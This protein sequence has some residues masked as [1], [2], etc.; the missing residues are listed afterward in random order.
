MQTVVYI[1]GAPV[2]KG[3][4][5]VAVQGGHAHAYTPQRTKDYEWLVQQCFAAQKCCVMPRGAALSVTVEA[6]CPVPESATKKQ[7]AEML[8]G[9]TMPT[10]KPDAD[11]VLKIILD[12]LNG[13]AY[14][15]DRQI[16]ALAIRKAYGEKPG[17][18][19]KI[20]TIEPEKDDE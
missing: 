8:A 7:R 10:K 13:V 12:A 5:R 9:R 3:R 1:P 17:V 4:P 2:G 16:V 20:R 11:N 19:V 18:R 14:E 6:V 15:D